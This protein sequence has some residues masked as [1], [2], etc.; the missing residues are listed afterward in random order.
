MKFN[1]IK[2]ELPEETIEEFSSST[3]FCESLLE[4]YGT[5]GLKLRRKDAGTIPFRE[6]KNEEF[7]I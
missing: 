1:N 2:D 4:Y 7:T 3:K 5:I 6:Y